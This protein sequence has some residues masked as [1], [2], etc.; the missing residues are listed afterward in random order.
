MYIKRPICLIS[1]ALAAVICVFIYIFPLKTSDEAVY[2]SGNEIIL[3]GKVVKKDVKKDKLRIFIEDIS[4]DEALYP[5]NKRFSR[6]IRGVIAE[7]PISEYAPCDIKIGSIVSLKGVYKIYDKPENE[8]Q[9]NS[10]QY[11]AIRGYDGAL[12]KAELLY[13]SKNYDKYRENLS[14]LKY[15]A[16]DIFNTYL[17]EQDSGIMQAMVLGDKND[18]DDE[19]RDIYS[20]AGISHVLS[21]SGLHIAA[22]G[23]FILGFLK[24]T[25]INN[26]ICCVISSF[27][28]LSYAIMTGFS[29]STVRALIMFILGVLA[30]VIGRTYD[31][32]SAAAFS[33]LLLLINNPYYLQDSGFLLSFGA[34]IGIS[35]VYPSFYYVFMPQKLKNAVDLNTDDTCPMKKKGIIFLRGLINGVISSVS[36]SFTTLPIVAYSFFKTSF[37]SFLANMIVIPLAGVLLATGF[38]AILFGLAQFIHGL[39]SI[40]LV[41]FI[42]AY[43]SEC[44][45]K[46]AHVIIAIYRR[47]S[48]SVCLIPGNMMVI[49]RPEIYKCVIY[50]TGLI[51]LLLIINHNSDMKLVKNTIDQ[52]SRNIANNNAWYNEKMHK[53][54][55]LSINVKNSTLR[56]ILKSFVILY[57]TILL[58]IITKR[59]TAPLEIR[60]LSVGQGDC[61]LITGKDA[62]VI[63]IDGGSTD[64]KNVGKYRIIPCVL[65]NGIN[66]I[67]YLIISHCDSDHVNGITELLNNELSGIAVDRILISESSVESATA[68]I[69]DD[70]VMSLTENR[71]ANRSEEVNS[72]NSNL[73]DIIGI[74]ENKG[75]AIYKLKSGDS[76]ID[77]D[78]VIECISP[79][80]VISDDINNN[81]LVVMISNKEVGYSALFT[82]DIGFDTEN[83]ISNKT[84]KA[85]YLKIAHHGSKNSSSL[86]FLK[87]VSASI[88]VISVAKDSPYGHP[89]QEA[90][91]RISETDSKLFRTDEM[92]EIIIKVYDD[93]QYVYGFSDDI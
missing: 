42:S 30:E 85:D 65:A 88:S 77:G 63:L 5:N 29:T 52:G 58:F 72:D 4:V 92:G 83:R 13:E 6:R 54:I 53:K 16:I 60:N 70:G 33:S 40:G 34:I 86:D 61:A 55:T 25:G 36:I 28:M 49:G 84:I 3:Q 38:V 91:D 39:S 69:G 79:D 82:G 76:I 1:V 62:P 41:L 87:S 35:L 51:I 11:Y 37:F 9:F 90:L 20:A 48:E 44:S 8:G 12:K 27:I 71:S 24:K 46:I 68:Q 74:A 32:L 19:V 75:I 31:L 50:Y 26:V 89:H 18:L 73:Q 64:I 21:L 57:I 14:I 2:F 17:N 56:V 66:R 67:D 47:V 78:T 10:W 45:L 15:H 80:A 22:V 23:L 7:L 81:S 59:D 43:G 93:K